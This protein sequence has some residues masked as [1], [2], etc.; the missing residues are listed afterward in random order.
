MIARAGVA[1]A[2]ARIFRAS[3]RSVIAGCRPFSTGAMAPW[4]IEA[5]S[6]RLSPLAIAKT[7][8]ADIRCRV[9]RAVS[10]ASRFSISRNMASTSGGSISRIGRVPM[11]GKTSRSSDRRTSSANRSLRDIL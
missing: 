4:T 2:S 7:K 3:A 11:A 8:T 6:V 5:G 1:S 10:R 9:R